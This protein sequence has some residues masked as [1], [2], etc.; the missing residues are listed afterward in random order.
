MA[1]RKACGARAQPATQSSRVT[2]RKDKEPAHSHVD[3][4]DF[5]MSYTDFTLD[6]VDRTL[7]MTRTEVVCARCGGHLGHL[8]DDGP[9]PTGLRYCM[10][11]VS[12]AFVPTK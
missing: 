12:L 6:T 5:S 2:R 9:P 4:D 3:R 1:Q 7:G 10:N 11:S 8:F